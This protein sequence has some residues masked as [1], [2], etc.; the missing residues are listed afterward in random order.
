MQRSF[1]CSPAPPKPPPRWCGRPADPLKLV[2]TDMTLPGD[3]LAKRYKMM[4]AWAEFIARPVVKGKV[5]DL[6]AVRGAA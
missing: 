5:T 4:N 3:M 1:P 6:G 2:V